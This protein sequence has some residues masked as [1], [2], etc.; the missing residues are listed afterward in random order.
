MPQLGLAMSGK[1]KLSQKPAR[2][3]KKEPVSPLHA[4]F[5]GYVQLSD[6]T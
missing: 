6:N 2:F 5:Q 1:K 4:N 3:N